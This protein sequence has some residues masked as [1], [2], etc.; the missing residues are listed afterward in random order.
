[1]KKIKYVSVLFLTFLVFNESIKSANDTS[2]I[3]VNLF[4]IPFVIFFVS[5]IPYLI[6]NFIKIK[7][8]KDESASFLN[9]YLVISMLIFV[10]MQFK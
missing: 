9:Y 4:A 8:Y 5:L 3:I 7:Y 2:T 10:V 1:M 6:I